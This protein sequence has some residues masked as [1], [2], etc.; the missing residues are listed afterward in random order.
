MQTSCDLSA[1]SSNSLI[2]TFTLKLQPL[3]ASGR[4]QPGQP[5]DVAISAIL[6][7]KPAPAAAAEATGSAG[8][9]SAPSVSGS[10]TES[11]AGASSTARGSSELQQFSYW[12]LAHRAAAG[13]PDFHDILYPTT[14]IRLAAP[15]DVGWLSGPADVAIKQG[16]A[17]AVS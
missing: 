6:H 1:G 13:K 5:L 12:A 3:V 8:A 14:A 17:C 7:H 4:L 2:A 9:S 16:W 11:E 15:H 10:T